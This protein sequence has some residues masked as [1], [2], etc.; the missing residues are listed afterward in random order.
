[1]I[2]LQR[3]RDTSLLRRPPVGTPESLGRP[4]S[5]TLPAR[6]ERMKDLV[7]RQPIR[8]AVALAVAG[9]TLTRVAVATAGD[10]PTVHAPITPS[11][12]VLVGMGLV[13]IGGVLR[14]LLGRKAGKAPRAL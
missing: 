13:L 8:L 5:R 6:K 7:F 2:M 1:M 3:L 10:A 9:I 11:S 4:A 14:R 12:V